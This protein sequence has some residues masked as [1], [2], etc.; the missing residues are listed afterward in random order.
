M[1]GFFFCPKAPTVPGSGGAALMAQMAVLPERREPDCGTV[2]QL[3]C[4]IPLS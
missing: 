3:P 2:S 4:I 1:G